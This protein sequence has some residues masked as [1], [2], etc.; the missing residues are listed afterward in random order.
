MFRVTDVVHL[1]DGE[2]IKAV[3]RKHGLTLWP[4]LLLAAAFIVVPFFFLFSLT[5]W[6]AIGMTIFATSI[7]LGIFFALRAFQL[8]QADVL[9]VTTD[10]IVDVDQRGLWNRLVTE[11]PLG[12]V[13]EVQCEHKGMGEMLCRIGTL[14]IRTTGA[15]PEIIAPRIS[16][17]ERWQGLINELRGR[18]VEP[19]PVMAVSDRRVR[20]QKMLE[21]ADERTV[22]AIQSVLDELDRPT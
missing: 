1:R 17:P 5:K 2:V 15:S 3:V 22:D 4:P 12:F 19:L 18:R 7:A 16:R 11:V 13:Q 9:M 8:W 10:R 20:V 21:S 6:G 14:R